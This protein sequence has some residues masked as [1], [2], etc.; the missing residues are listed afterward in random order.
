MF[1]DTMP[2]YA[3]PYHTKLHHAILCSATRSLPRAGARSLS[4][5]ASVPPPYEGEASARSHAAA[6]ESRRPPR[7]LAIV[8]NGEVP[9]VHKILVVY[10]C[11]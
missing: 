11:M 2:Y 9:E 1:C 10:V 4:R 8:E 6:P 5:K 3:I 7:P